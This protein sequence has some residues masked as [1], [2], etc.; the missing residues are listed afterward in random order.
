MLACALAPNMVL[1]NSARKPVRT[2][3]VA[4]KANTASEI[5]M[6]DIQVID[7]IPPSDLL[8]RR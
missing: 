5:P 6:S 2:A 8:D 7:D 4:I 1:T 3:R